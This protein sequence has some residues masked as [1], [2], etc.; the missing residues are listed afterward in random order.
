LS[1]NGDSRGN[2]SD[3]NDKPVML[4]HRRLCESVHN[5]VKFW[6]FFARWRKF[7]AMDKPA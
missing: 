4:A 7:R 5:A 6:W 1:R 2:E 3:N